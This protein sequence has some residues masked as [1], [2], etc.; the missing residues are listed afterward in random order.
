M[1]YTEYAA[2]TENRLGLPLPATYKRMVSD[3]LLPDLCAVGFEFEIPDADTLVEYYG[4][5]ADPDSLLPLKAQYLNSVAPF[6]GAGNGD[7][8]VFYYEN[9]AA[10]P[11][12]ARLVHDDDFCEILAKNF[13]DFVFRKL[14]SAANECYETDSEDYRAE[15]LAQLET[16]RPYLTPERAA[17]LA[18]TY[19]RPFSRDQWDDPYILEEDEL[20]EL[21]QRHAPFARYDEEWDAIEWG[22]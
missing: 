21:L 5:F 6:A 19:R 18:E 15:L 13:D 17:A 4:E 14:L 10:E 1:N 20:N 22:D 16:H 9:G 12:V 2:A 7:V 3:G 8:Y 11:L